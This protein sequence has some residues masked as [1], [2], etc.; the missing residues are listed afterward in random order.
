M[1]TETDPTDGYAV[2]AGAPTLY[3]RA[4]LKDWRLEFARPFPAWDEWPGHYFSPGARRFFSSRVLRQCGPYVLESV[5]P[6]HGPREYRIL[7]L[8][9]KAGE[10]ERLALPGQGNPGP[11]GREPVCSRSYATRARAVGAWERLTRSVTGARFQRPSNGGPD[12]TGEPMVPFRADAGSV[13]RLLWHVG[14]T[15]ETRLPVGRLSVDPNDPTQ[16]HADG[17]D[18][19]TGGWVRL[20]SVTRD[21]NTQ[22]WEI[23]G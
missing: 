21:P 8:D 7:L 17:F 13:Q 9:P 11:P 14:G 22:E 1:P 12:W 19:S 18:P 10:V 5:R 15:R 16:I 2:R 20:A 4:V 23:C 6:P 3:G